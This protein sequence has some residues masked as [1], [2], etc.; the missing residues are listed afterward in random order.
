MI[1]FDTLFYTF[2]RVVFFQGD[3]YT[4][5]PGPKGYPGLPGPKGFPGQAGPPGDGLQ[6]PKG[7]QGPKGNQGLTGIPGIPGRPGPPGQV[8]H[9]LSLR[10]VSWDLK[11]NKQ[12]TKS[13]I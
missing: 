7:E 1:H 6:G 11:T 13:C 2:D 10:K 3:G 8:S 12:T 4:G 5:L 9:D